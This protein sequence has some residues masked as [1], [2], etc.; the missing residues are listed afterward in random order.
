MI[1]LPRLP[2]PIIG[3]VGVLALGVY[4]THRA[5][6]PQFI[7]R[8]QTNAVTNNSTISW[9]LADLTD[10]YGFKVQIDGGSFVDVGIPTTQ[11]PCCGGGITFTIS[12]SLLG[13]SNGQHTL[14]IYAYNVIGTLSSNPVQ[15]IVTKS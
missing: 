15:I 5:A 4:A 6:E 7:V 10:L 2:P 3:L 12:V 11:A 9:D 14:L 1:G 13:L 8:V